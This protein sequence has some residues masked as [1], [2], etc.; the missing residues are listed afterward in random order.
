MLCKVQLLWSIAEIHLSPSIPLSQ[1]LIFL[2]FPSFLL[3]LTL[4][5]TYI[6]PILL[7]FLLLSPYFLSFPLLSYISSLHPS[8]L[9]FLLSSSLLFPSFLKLFFFPPSSPPHIS[10]L[11]L[12][13]YLLP[14]LS[15][16]LSTILPLYP[17]SFSQA[18]NYNIT[19]FLLRHSCVAYRGWSTDHC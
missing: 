7:I 8:I 4:L 10:Y 11:Y 1:L 12:P 13:L 14:P 17:H 3:S 9:L 6:L 15:F 2:L 19:S 5:C 18:A 16:L